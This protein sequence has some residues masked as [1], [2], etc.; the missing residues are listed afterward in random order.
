M[1]NSKV[2]GFTLIELIVVIAII[3]IL[4]AILVPSMLGYLRNA[5]LNSANANAKIVHTAVSTALTQCAVANDVAS[6]E[7]VQVDEDNCTFTGSNGYSCDLITYLGTNYSG[8]G[9]AKVD[10]ASYATEYALWCGTQSVMNGEQ[11]SAA[12]QEEEADN[13][14]TIIGCYPLRAY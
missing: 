10:T 1:R 12:S 11:E 3:G 14:G 6:S 5:R 4:A 13:S 7:D 2:K 9:Y 8:F